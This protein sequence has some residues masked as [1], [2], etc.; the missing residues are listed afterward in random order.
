MSNWRMKPMNAEKNRKNTE[1]IPE[2]KVVIP[3]PLFATL[4]LAVTLTGA[5]VIAVLACAG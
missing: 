2:E 3:I 4:P 1:G 5:V